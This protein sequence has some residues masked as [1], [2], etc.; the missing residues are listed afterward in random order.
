MWWRARRLYITW[1]LHLASY[2]TDLSDVEVHCVACPLH[3]VHLNSLSTLPGVGSSSYTIWPL[4]VK[5]TQDHSSSRFRV[6]YCTSIHS[7]CVTAMSELTYESLADD[8]GYLGAE[9]ARMENKMILDELER[10]KKARA[11]AVP[12]DDN[13]VKARLREIGEPITLFGERVGFFCWYW[14]IFWCVLCVIG[15]R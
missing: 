7:L 15:C 3:Y 9:R 5:C 2:D 4:T 8:G 11:M 13:R 1:L 6:H 10:K 14:C 12:T